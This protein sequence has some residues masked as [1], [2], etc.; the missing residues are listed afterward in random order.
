MTSYNPDKMPPPLSDSGNY[1]DWKKMV[2]IWSTFTTLPKEKQGTTI[3]LSLK[4]QDQ[5]AV[6]ELTSAQI[7]AAAG[8]DA[9]INRLDSLY[10]K[11]TTLQKYKALENFESYRRTPSTSINNF[12]CGFE[13]RHH[14]IKSHGTTIS[15][16]LL[17]FCLLKSANLPAA[18]EKLAKGTAELTYTSMK[19]QLKKLFSDSNSLPST[20][21][22]TDPSR[23]EEINIHESYNE[24]NAH[25]TY[26]NSRGSRRN[27]RGHYPRNFNR[28]SM[29]SNWRTP[30]NHQEKPIQRNPRDQHGNITKCN[31]CESVMHWAPKCPHQ[32]NSDATYFSLSTPT[33]GAEDIH[34]SLP[35]QL[36]QEEYEI[37][38]HQSDHDTPQHM[39]SLILESTDYAVLDCG[40]SRTVAGAS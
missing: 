16:D 1:E 35:A 38:L 17:A 2:Q 5:E 18:D 24:D 31:I 6:L 4:G 37:V 12:I 19:D 27:Y 3:L 28:G 11:D 13:K 40:A 23:F 8:L 7:T 9:V 26:Y 39:N 21:E 33:S 25:N 34:L 10:L 32:K 15:D 29:N 30:S 22:T 14:K 36:N 20:A